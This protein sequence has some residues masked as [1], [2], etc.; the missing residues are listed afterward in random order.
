MC[1]SETQEQF[2]HELPFVH[3]RHSPHMQPAYPQ[4]LVEDP[5]VTATQLEALAELCLAPGRSWRCAPMA[6]SLLGF[7]M[8]KAMLPPPPSGKGDGDGK[9][10]VAA[11]WGGQV[12]ADSGTRIVPRVSMAP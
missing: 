3:H 2:F 5:V 11:Q 7:A 9:V 4:L 1:N 10:V 8:R 12:Q 6:C